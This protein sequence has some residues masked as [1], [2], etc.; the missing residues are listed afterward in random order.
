MLTIINKS[1]IFLM[2]LLIVGH[3]QPTMAAGGCETATDLL[4]RAYH[5]YRQGSNVFQQKLLFNRSLQLCSNLPEVHTALASIF[6]QQ[7]KLSQAIYHYQQSVSLKPT[8]SKA[9]AQLGKIFYQENQFP[10]SMEAY[11]QAC[12]KDPAS[13]EQVIELLTNKRYTLTE[14]DQLTKKESLLVLFNLKRRSNLRKMIEDCDLEELGEI[15]DVK[16]KHTFFNLTFDINEAVLPPAAQAQL[17]EIG[18]ALLEVS[19]RRVIHIHGHS[20]HKPFRYANP[21]ESEKRNQELS[22]QRA[23]AVAHTLEKQG[24]ALTRFKIHAHGNNIPLT[25]EDSPIALEKN[26]RIEIEVK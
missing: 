5:L 2:A 21:E 23:L 13:K 22:Q 4:F 8:F 25:T 6:E 14:K 3:P 10:I 1:S 15:S 16:P 9:W 11:L 18:G 20:D 17:E 26:R 24:I 12:Q 19:E 7:G